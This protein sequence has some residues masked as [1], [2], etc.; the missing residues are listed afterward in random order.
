MPVQIKAYDY[1]YQNIDA[2]SKKQFDVHQELYKGYVNKI[3]EIWNKLA[4]DAERDQANA[5]YSYYRGLKLGE[6]YA[7]DGV[8]LHELYFSNLGGNRTQAYGKALEMIRRDF[9]TYESWARDFTACGKAGRGWAILAYDQR[10]RTLHNF[11]CDAH[12][13]GAIWTAYP[14]LIMDVYEHAYFIDYANKKDEY[15]NAFMK[16]IDW[17]VVNKR[18]GIL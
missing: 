9:G 11:M 8:I 12:D 2:I 10:S 18:A 7:L 6:T 5:T 14:V 3:N 1:P 16:D 4:G 15:I 13:V 17:D